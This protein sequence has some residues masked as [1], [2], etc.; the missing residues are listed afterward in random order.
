ISTI[1]FHGENDDI[2][3]YIASRK[4]AYQLFSNLEFNTT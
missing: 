1:I 3:Q 2:A 4:R